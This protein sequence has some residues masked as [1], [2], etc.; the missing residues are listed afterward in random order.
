MT[1][2]TSPTFPL[3]PFSKGVVLATANIAMDGTGV[4]TDAAVTAGSDGMML[5]YVKVRHKGTNAATVLRIWIYD[6]SS[7]YSLFAERTIASNTISQTAE[8]V[9]A[10]VPLNL[11]VP[12]GYQLKYTIGTTVAAGLYLTVVGGQ[13]A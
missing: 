11:R 5:E 9:E 4:M 10:V 12:S 13:Y 6:G 3:T 8:S 7:V 1:M 2:N